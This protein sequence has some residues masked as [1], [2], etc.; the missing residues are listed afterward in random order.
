MTCS[1]GS[2]NQHQK[3]E[4]LVQAG[5]QRRKY[6]APTK[7]STGPL[8]FRLLLQQ[9]EAISVQFDKPIRCSTDRVSDEIYPLLD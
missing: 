1:G 2:D 3:F 6:P 5:E 4:S 9:A 7:L 8:L